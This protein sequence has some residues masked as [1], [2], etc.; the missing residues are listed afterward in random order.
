MP[1][2]PEKFDTAMTT[3]QEWQDAPW[4][5]LRY[6]IAEANL[7]RHLDSL[8]G[9]PLRILDLAGGDGGDAIRLAA[10]GHHVTIADYAPAM[11][12]SATERAAA[13]GLTELITCVEA[14]VTDL[15]ADLAGGEFDIVLCHNLLQYMDDIPGV[16]AAVLA[17]LKP[18]G[19]VSVMAINRHSAP[20]NIAIRQ[21][22]PMAAHAALETDQAR[23]EMFNSALTLHAAEEI[24]PILQNLG[25][26]DVSH[27]G[28]RSFCDYITD[29]ARKHDPAFY[30]DLERLE[31]ATTARHPY[32]H[33]ARIFQL[34]A[35][36]PTD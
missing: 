16:L 20:L 25:C 34:T 2:A 9:G 31:L 28:I 12:A 22:D 18:G 11:L 10:R 32:M 36:K 21:M 23:T 27:Y 8:D 35:W 4:G 15:P 19:L 29:D 5:R 14:D 3:W 7:L 13:S 17:P 30:A 24:I 26:R 33:T 6:S 1:E